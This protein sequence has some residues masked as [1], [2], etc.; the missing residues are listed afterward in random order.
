[1]G[2]VL[3]VVGGLVGLFGMFGVVGSLVDPPGVIL[4]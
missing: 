4:M 2:K 3:L 1:M